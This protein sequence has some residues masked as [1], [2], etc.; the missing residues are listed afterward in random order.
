MNPQNN[1]IRKL[2]RLPEKEDDNLNKV[3]KNK[4]QGFSKLADS[5]Y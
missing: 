3:N 1:N 2:H 4:F 5:N